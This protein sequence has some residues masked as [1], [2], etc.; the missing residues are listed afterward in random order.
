MSSLS[1]K[2]T[3]ALFDAPGVSS[4]LNIKKQQ[5][6]A[7]R[8]APAVAAEASPAAAAVNSVRTRAQSRSS[9]RRSGGVKLLMSPSRGPAGGDAD[10]Q[11]TLGVRGTLKS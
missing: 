7:A 8:S 5:T 2:V 3:K 10:G 6:A 4:L 9:A 1:K 11:T